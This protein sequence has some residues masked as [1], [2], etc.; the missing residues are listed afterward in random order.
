MGGRHSIEFTNGTNSD[1]NDTIVWQLDVSHRSRTVDVANSR[2]RYSRTYSITALVLECDALENW[3]WIVPHGL[4]ESA[5]CGSSGDVTF[6]TVRQPLESAPELMPQSTCASRKS[7]GYFEGS[8]AAWAAPTV[9]GF[10]HVCGE[11]AWHIPEVDTGSDTPGVTY[12]Q[13]LKNQY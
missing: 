11:S 10:P 12:R 4:D 13:G 1:D 3:G 2:K 9:E 5:A 8:G 7:C 6:T